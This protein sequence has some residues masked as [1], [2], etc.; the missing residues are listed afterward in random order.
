MSRKEV[1]APIRQKSM[2]SSNGK[3][4]SDYISCTTV[5]GGPF[6][7]NISGKSPGCEII[8]IPGIVCI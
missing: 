4:R 6:V 8:R 3:K 1:I 2:T 7:A 5:T